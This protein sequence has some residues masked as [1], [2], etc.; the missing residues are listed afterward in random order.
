MKKTFIYTLSDIR[1]DIRYV[2]KTN[3]EIKKRLY[4]HIIECKS[5]RTTHKINWIKSLLDKGERP[6]IEVVEE[7]NNDIWQEREIY[8]IEQFRQWGFNLTNLTLGGDGGNG[9]KHTKISKEKMRSSKLG[10][11]LPEE[12]KERISNSIKEKY[13]E[14]SNYNKCCDKI[15]IIDKDILYQKYIIENLSMPKLSIFFNVSEKTIFNN[16]NEY[17]IKK[18]KSIWLKQLSPHT[19]KVVLQYDLKGSFIK[20]WSSLI[21]IEEELSINKSNIANCCRGIANSVCGFIWRYKDNFIDIDLTKLKKG[22]EVVQYSKNNEFI[23]YFESIKE[24]GLSTGV[25]S[26][27]IQDCCVGRLKSAGGFIWRYKSDLDI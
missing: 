2:G 20:E 3:N 24:A 16:L 14:N 8:W 19:K 10:T 22:R 11:K 27:N 7:V 5:N 9:Y 18:D 23:N 6:I 1:G 4:A 26:N 21:A 12:H 25:R 17:G 13:R 15:H